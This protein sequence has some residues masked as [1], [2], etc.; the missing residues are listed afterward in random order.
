MHTQVTTVLVPSFTLPKEPIAMGERPKSM[1]EQKKLDSI[2]LINQT[3]LRLQIQEQWKS[4][5]EK[6]S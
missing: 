2:D 3:A 1:G 4:I 5:E 6:V